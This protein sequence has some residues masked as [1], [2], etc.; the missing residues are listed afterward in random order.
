MSRI[1]TL[2]NDC[3][4][5]EIST[6]GAELQ[7]ILVDGKERLWDGN[8][9]I[10]NGHAPLLFPVCG[11]L[12]DNKYYFEG[13]EYSFNS[14]HGFAKNLE[15]EVVAEENTQATFLIESNEQTKAMY[16]FEFAFRVMYKLDDNNLKV[17]YFVENNGDKEMYYNVGC[18]EAFMLDSDLENYSLEFSEDSGAL[19]NMAYASNGLLHGYFDIALN[20]NVLP[21]STD[22]FTGGR[23]LDCGYAIHDSL[24]VEDIKSKRI[25]L[26]KNGEKVL[27]IYFND[28]RNLVVW[29]KRGS[30]FLA[31]EPWDGLPDYA[32]CSH[33][34]TEKK[35]IAVLKAGECKTFYHSVTFE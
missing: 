11:R 1:V 22:L 10:W 35:G 17:Y 18:H 8:P 3:M 31:I 21:L 29:T 20:G 16:P 9:E 15:F 26:L 6:F 33:Q 25:N 12:N 7:R 13:K 24:I 23:Q 5:V 28:F 4:Q 32:D 30:R 34:L 2:K 19:K 27:S 14:I